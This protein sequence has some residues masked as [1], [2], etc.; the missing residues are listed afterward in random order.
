M[1]K[2]FGTFGGVFTPSIL[3]I[4]G[5]IMYLRLPLIIGQAGLYST[6]LIILLAHVISISTGL[7]VASI[8]TDKKV[9][10]GGTYFMISRSLGLPIGG[11]LGL[12]L[13]V[14]LS[15]SIS[16][17][18][19][20]FSESFLSFLD[21]E[22]TLRNIRI[23]GSFALL[24]VTTITFISTSLAIKSQYLIMAAILLSLTSI[25]FGNHEFAPSAPLLEPAADALPFMLLFGIFF[26][27]VTGFEAGVSMS[28][29]LENPK[30]SIPSGTIAAIAIGLLVYIGL[31]FFFSYTVDREAL[32]GDSNVLL[33]ISWVPE[34]VVAGIW[35]ATLSSALGS[36]LGA[37]RI[38]QATA[39]DKITS[40][41]FAKGYGPTKEPRN[42]LLLTFFIAEA[43]ILI[44]Q[45][46]VIA[47]VVSMFFITTYGFLN[48]SATIESWASSDFRPEFK[49]PRWVSLVGALACF[50]VMIQLDFAALIGA[51]II[52]GLLFLYLKRQELILSGGDAWGSLWTSI[53][54]SSLK[55]LQQTKDNIRNWR[56]NMLLFSGSDRK[57]YLQDMARMLSG[58]LG[59]VTNFELTENTQL[60]SPLVK[61]KNASEESGSH[62]FTKRHTCRNIYE[63]IDIISNSFGF[64][65]LEPNTIMMGWTRNTREPEKFVQLLKKFQQQNY[66]SVLLSYNVEKGFG[67]RKRICIWWNGE[68]NTLSFSLA[69]IRFLLTAQEWSGALVFIYVVVESSAAINSIQSVINQVMDR[70]RIPYRVKVINNSIEHRPIRDIIKAESRNTDLSFLGISE[71]LYVKPQD[72][73]DEF[74][75]LLSSVGTSLIVMGSDLF[76]SNTSLQVYQEEKTEALQELPPLQQ[77]EKHQMLNRLIINLDLQGRQV[78][79]HFFDSSLRNIYAAK[80]ELLNELNRLYKNS[81][82]VLRKEWNKT[83]KVRKQRLYNKIYNEFFY[84]ADQRVSQSRLISVLTEGQLLSTSLK[85]YLLQIHKIIDDMPRQQVVIY[86]KGDFESDPNDAFKL[87]IYKIRKR[88]GGKSIGVKLRLQDGVRNHLGLVS[89]IRFYYHLRLFYL[90]NLDFFSQLRNY[91]IEIKE[92]FDQIGFHLNDEG[93]EI[94]DLDEMEAKMQ[95]ENQKVQEKIVVARDQHWQ[96]MVK[97]YRNEINQFAD[98]INHV[99][100]NFRIGKRSKIL[101]QQR[102]IEHDI[103]NFTETWGS[104][105]QLSENT[106]SID[107]RMIALRN[108][109]RVNLLRELDQIRLPID[110]FIRNTLEAFVKHNEQLS[111]EGFSVPDLE[112]MFNEQVEK[113]VQDVF[114]EGYEDIKNNIND[115]PEELEVTGDIYDNESSGSSFSHLSSKIIPLRSLVEQHL[116]ENLLQPMQKEIQE[117][118]TRIG[119]IKHK[120]ADDI[121]LL[122][123]NFE[124]D[125]PILGINLDENLPDQLIGKVNAELNQLKEDLN[126]SLN[127]LSQR[128]QVLLNQSFDTLNSYTLIKSETGFVRQLR[129]DQGRKLKGQLRRVSTRSSDWIYQQVGRLI[130]SRSEGL[131]ISHRIRTRESETRPSTYKIL[132]FVEEQMPRQEVIDR[133]PYYYKN[134]FSGKSIV[135]DEFWIG[136]SR[137]M[138]I[139]DQSIQRF[140][141]G[142]SGGLLIT[143]PRKSGRTSLLR[144]VAYKYFDRTKIFSINLHHNEGGNLP[145]FTDLLQKATM[146]TGSP[147]EIIA[148][149]PYDSVVLIGDLEM[150]WQRN[151][152]GQ[153]VVDEIL[154]LISKFGSKTLFLIDCNLFTFLYMNRIHPMDDFFLAVISIEPFDAED[155]KNAVMSRHQS[156]GLKLKLADKPDY[157]LSAWG[158]AGLFNDYFNYSSGKVGTAL[159]AWLAGIKS[160]KDNAI[161]IKKPDKSTSEALDLLED[162][163][164]VLLVQFLIHGRMSKQKLMEIMTESPEEVQRNLNSLKRAGLIQEYNNQ[165]YQINPFVESHLSDKLL[166]KEII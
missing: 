15:L 127:K 57:V 60:S 42:A 6:L 113:Q 54:V 166:E 89:Q 93:F 137:E 144:K 158:I 32:V 99:D 51:T 79:E 8:A 102:K 96:E 139:A 34:L 134:L 123:Y 162:S 26:P 106:F 47:R 76:D 84:Q 30:K 35:G 124:S 78:L 7:S 19:I 33:N 45:L 141:Q 21:I 101:K 69:L 27:A 59:I 40:R 61:E 36:I 104:N 105:L 67:E 73:I 118:N 157:E 3:T 14:G 164:I 97:D 68:D 10:T 20:G 39:I 161:L 29:D 165:L 90:N 4:L 56:P 72:Y 128:I 151:L 25:F 83:E 43:G 126:A 82:E 52:L 74:N 92:Q 125:S 136:R 62:F 91:F 12:A 66:N 1:A 163:W 94:R 98:E 37:P 23:T 64:S 44:G 152:E 95:Q 24:A 149:L 138:K 119:S 17:Y 111:K 53:A 81:L 80:I 41:V 112:P 28:G 58:K 148:D 48:L 107:V 5:V 156:S 88:F 122:R 109:L 16:L 121:K 143:G 160:M 155:L 146:R 147:E 85:E 130:Y 87:K 70:Y 49:I 108:R 142:N 13:F 46:D 71:K 132:N 38:L 145:L 63:G 115:L 159:N 100:A 120:M 55:N 154:K 9:K 129:D 31:A 86:E 2:K 103:L 65:G 140:R 117:I 11:T 133:L 114:N 153:Q 77:S 75:V 110:A 135:G 150:W 116:E 22:P 50:L 18:L 131:L